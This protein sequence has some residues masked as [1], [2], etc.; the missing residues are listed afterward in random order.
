MQGAGTGST[1]WLLLKI[2][3]FSTASSSEPIFHACTIPNSAYV[4]FDF[5]VT[6]FMVLFVIKAESSTTGR[7]LIQYSF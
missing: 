1:G 3:H 7:A 2:I 6:L 4:Y 5:C